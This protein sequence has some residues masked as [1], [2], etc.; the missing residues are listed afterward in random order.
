MLT[1]SYNKQ[2]NNKIN[3]T[4]QDMD[5]TIITSQQLVNIKPYCLPH[6]EFGVKAETG[7]VWK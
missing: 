3:V 7:Y 6:L 4:H 2:K 5:L 1:V